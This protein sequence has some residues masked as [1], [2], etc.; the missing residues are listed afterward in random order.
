MKCLGN[1]IICLEKTFCQEN[2]CTVDVFIYFITQVFNLFPC[3]DLSIDLGQL[4][5][6]IH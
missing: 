1:I 3:L 5:N 2:M 6:N 4:Y